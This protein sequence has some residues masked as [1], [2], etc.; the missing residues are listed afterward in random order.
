MHWFSRVSHAKRMHR[1]PFS[2]LLKTDQFPFPSPLPHPQF[3]SFP[4]SLQQVAY[5]K[6]W[7]RNSSVS[8]CSS[9]WW[10]G[11]QGLRNIGISRMDLNTEKTRETH[12]FYTESTRGSFKNIIKSFYLFYQLEL[13]QEI[14]NTFDCSIV[15]E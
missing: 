13:F 11:L 6:E 4:P 15:C 1:K 12:I 10:S 7:Q 14:W 9:P 3:S 8:D 2:W 5:K